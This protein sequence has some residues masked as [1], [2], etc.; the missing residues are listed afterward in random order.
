MSDFVISSER[1]RAEVWQEVRNDLRVTILRRLERRVRLPVH[2]PP[3][4]EARDRALPPVHARADVELDLV[5]ASL[6]GL[7]VR[8]PGG[9]AIHLA[10]DH[11]ADVPDAAALH[12][13]H[14]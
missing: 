12:Q 9:L 8:E 1:L 14:T 13:S 5:G 6:G 11:L 10:V 4:S 7:P 2:S 3:F